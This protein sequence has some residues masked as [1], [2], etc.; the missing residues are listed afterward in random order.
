MK[1]ENP[2]RHKVQEAEYFLSKMKEILEDENVF[3]YNLSA[4]S[5]AAR[6]ITFYMQKQYRSKYGKDFDEWYRPKEQKMKDDPELKY[7]NKVR[8][9]A[10]H[11]ETI[12]TGAT[13]IKT[14]SLG[15]TVGKD[16]PEAEQVNE[17]ESK[18][19]A[20]SS[21]K[22]VGRFYPEFK[23]RDVI[24]FGEKQLAKLT[25]VVE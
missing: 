23:N 8:A 10:I 5:S 13:R 2:T 6:S 7:L 4:F 17:A 1:I 3:Y 21:P 20:Q 14:S 19:A 24:E 12:E 25:K 18:P 22:T 15:L 11:T 16:T 9:E